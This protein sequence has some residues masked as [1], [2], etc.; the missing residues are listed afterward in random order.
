[1]LE[2]EPRMLR[3]ANIAVS[4]PGPG[5]TTVETAAGPVSV[6]NVHGLASS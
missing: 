4:A 3:P 6:V 2:A 5:L 1:M